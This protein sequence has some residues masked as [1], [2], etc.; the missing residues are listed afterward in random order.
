MREL[1]VPLL[2][3]KFSSSTLELHVGFCCDGDDGVSFV[4]SGKK[5]HESHPLKKQSETP[6]TEKAISELEVLLSSLPDY[7]KNVL[8][9]V[10]GVFLPLVS[11]PFPHF[12][13][14]LLFSLLKQLIKFFYLVTKQSE[15]NKMNSQNMAIVVLNLF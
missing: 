8:Q 14:F 6:D 7:T 1:P 2:G 9:M 12:F 5:I 15:K 10:C 13:S 3:R 11:L 4:V